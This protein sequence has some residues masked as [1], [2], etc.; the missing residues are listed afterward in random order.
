M[1]LG[2]FRCQAVFPERVAGCLSQRGYCVVRT[3]LSPEAQA[4][5][6]GQ[7]APVACL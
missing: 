7:A 3:F 1:L 2:A 5:A 4:K 6:R